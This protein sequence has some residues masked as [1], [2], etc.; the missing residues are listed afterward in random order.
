M[1]KKQGKNGNAKLQTKSDYLFSMSYAP[2]IDE[3]VHWL[4]LLPIAFFGAFVIIIVKM[5]SYSRNMEQ[6]YWS[7]GNSNLTD[8]FSYYKMVAILI[9]AVLTLV[10]LL[11]RLCTQS[12]SIKRCFAYIPMIIYSVMVLVSYLLSDYKEF[13]LLGYN[14]RFEGTLTLLAYMVMLF[15]II[16]TIN[17][18]SGIKWA[19]YPIAVSSALLG[20]LG[21]S[22]ATGHDFFRSSIGQKLVTPNTSVQMTETFL[23][24][25]VGSALNEAGLI[26]QDSYTTNELIDMCKSIDIDFLG[27][28]FNNN[29][30]YQTVYNINYVSF[31]LTL[32]LPLFGMLFIR[33]VLRGKEEPVWKKFIWGALFALLVFNLIGSASS[34]G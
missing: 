6:F 4:Q 8:F 16:N 32:L 15:F 14:D 22:Q 1:S 26:T 21:I 3:S 18:E 17:T 9:C 5:Y 33:S 12:L 23:N 19:V 31:Y 28:T 34:G 29:E 11:Y 13:S 27:F 24:G 30:I 20:I 25:R 10:L 2:K 7:S